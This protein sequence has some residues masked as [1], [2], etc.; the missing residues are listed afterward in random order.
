MY[1]GA[2]LAARAKTGDL[3]R[4]WVLLTVALK[5]VGTIGAWPPWLHCYLM[6][7]RGIVEVNPFQARDLPATQF[8]L[9][10]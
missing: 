6:A 4:L 8:R 2:T 7:Y 1:L 5:V 3:Q 10:L 9:L